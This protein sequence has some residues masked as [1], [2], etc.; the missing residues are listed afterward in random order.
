MGGGLWVVGVGGGPA[1]CVFTVKRSWFAAI[2]E[3]DR[4]RFLNPYVMSH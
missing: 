3:A 2:Q 4:P 1:A